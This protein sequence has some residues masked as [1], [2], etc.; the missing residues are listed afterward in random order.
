ML[1]ISSG[2]G[3]VGGIFYLIFSSGKEQSWDK[4]SLDTLSVN[5]DEDSQSNH[6]CDYDD[7]DD[8]LLRA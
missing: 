5:G 7:D 1:F 2:I 3:I 8:Q 6:S 4:I